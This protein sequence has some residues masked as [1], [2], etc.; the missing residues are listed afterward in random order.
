MRVLKFVSTQYFLETSA[1]VC[2]DLAEVLRIG[3]AISISHTL[4]L[5]LVQGKRIKIRYHRKYNTRC[6]IIN[7]QVNYECRRHDTPAKPRVARVPK[8]RTE[9]WVHTDKKNKSSVGAALSARAFALR[10]GSAAP[11]GAQKNVCQCLTQGLS[12]G[13]GGSIAL[14]GSSTSSSITCLF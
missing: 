4:T 10:L 2:T 5:T 3:H 11:K 14:K 8:A 12:P 7:I 9:P 6:V 13:L 1:E